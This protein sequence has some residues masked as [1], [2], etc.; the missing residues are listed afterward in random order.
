METEA[1]SVESKLLNE[2]LVEIKAKAKKE[3]Y[4]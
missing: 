2:A 3:Y 4:E 1:V